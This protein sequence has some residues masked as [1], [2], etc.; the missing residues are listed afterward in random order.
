MQKGMILLWSGAIVDIPNG[1]HLCD[2]TEDTPDLRNRFVIGAGDTYNLGDTGGAANHFHTFT[3]D[4]HYHTL[5]AGND[6]AA[7]GDYTEETSSTAV[8]GTTNESSSL[9]PYYAL[10]YIMRL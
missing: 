6:V 5:E 7:G 1:W 8:T 2:G 10:A 3:G 4:S 9:P